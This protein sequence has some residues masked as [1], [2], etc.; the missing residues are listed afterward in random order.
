[1]FENRDTIP[2]PPGFWHFSQTPPRCL[3]PWTGDSAVNLDVFSGLGAPL[4]TPDIQEP[5][6]TDVSFP[7]S[8]FS[9]WTQ[10]S[11]IWGGGCSLPLCR[12]WGGRPAILS[13]DNVTRRALCPAF[14]VHPALKTVQW[15]QAFSVEPRDPS[16]SLG[17]FMTISSS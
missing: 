2:L 8:D 15:K 5:P 13:S 7:L 10:P 4:W 12:T 17:W 16:L 9:P 1:M 14:G 11:R 3:G 6:E